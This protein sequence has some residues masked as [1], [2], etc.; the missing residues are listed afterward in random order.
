MP[1]ATDNLDGLNKKLSIDQIEY[2]MEIFNRQLENISQT[3]LDLKRPYIVQ[4][5]RFDPSKGIP[6]VIESFRKLR[7]MLKENGMTKDLPQLVIAGHGSI[8][9]PE[10]SIVYEEVMNILKSDVFEN[11]VDDIKIVRLSNHDQV[12]NALF[13]KSKIV[14][15][16]SHREGFEV[17]V[18]EALEKGKLVIAYKTGGIP[19]QIENGVTGYLVRIGDT[20]Q[21]AKYMFELLSDKNKY[22]KMCRNAAEKVNFDYFTVGNASNWLYLATELLEKGKVLGNTRRVD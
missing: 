15:Q 8:D 16:L 17:K 19:L 13:R 1:A 11:L 4:I 7:K 12:L 2:Y 22:E 20:K 6:D 3:P 21:V 5:A 10:A 18:S 14:L 9:D